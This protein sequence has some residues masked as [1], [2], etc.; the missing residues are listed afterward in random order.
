EAIQHSGW[1]LTFNDQPN[2]IQTARDEVKKQVTLM[3]SI[4]MIATTEG[5]IQ[6]VMYDGPS[7]KAGLGP[8]MKITEVAGK[9][10]SPAALKDS[11]AASATSPVQLTVANGSQVQTYSI[12]YHGGQQYPH[13]KRLQN[14]PD[15]LDEI[16]RPLAP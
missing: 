6:E 13:L 4:G 10:F 8:G 14:R 7:F 5:I 3:Y 2:E 15:V 1:Q 12:E 11:V 16:Y 9:P